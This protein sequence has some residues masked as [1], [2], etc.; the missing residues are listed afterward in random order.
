MV[1][2][3]QTVNIF[4]WNVQYII[5]HEFLHTLGFYHEQSR[6][7]RNNYIQVNCNFVQGGCGGLIFNPNFDIPIL[8]TAYGYYDFDSVMH[9]GQ[10]AFTTGSNCPADN[11]QTI[12]VLAPNQ[13]QQT[14]I[15]QRTH[16]SELDKATVSFLYPSS[17]WRFYDCTYP[18]ILGT[19]TFLHPYAD[20]VNALVA[21]PP[22]GT[23]WVLKNCS[24]PVRTYNQSVTVKVAPGVIA[25]FGN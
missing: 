17:D 5:V 18:P 3:G 2:F 9:Y 11:S 7:D 8:A 15:G 1:G 4:N 24:F 10:C 6:P 23:L 25:T 20:P 12:T 13:N 21:T 22:G 19:G 16:L 14:L